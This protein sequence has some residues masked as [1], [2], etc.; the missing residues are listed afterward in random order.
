MVNDDLTLARVLLDGF[1]RG[2]NGQQYLDNE[3]EARRALVRL[4][5]SD[6]PLDR[7]VRDGLAALFDPD[8][9]LRIAITGVIPGEGQLLGGFT[10][11]DRKRQ[12]SPGGDRRL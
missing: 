8:N 12:T 3:R 10:P 9:E 6:T 7:D 1:I 5:R 11:N 4:L 2:D